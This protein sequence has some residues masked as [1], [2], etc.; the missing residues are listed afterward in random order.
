MDT[1]TS[2][3]RGHRLHLSARR[4]QGMRE[5]GLSEE[6]RCAEGW[7]HGSLTLRRKIRSGRQRGGEDMTGLPTKKDYEDYANQVRLVVGDKCLNELQ[8][9]AA[10]EYPAISTRLLCGAEVYFSDM[11]AFAEARQAGSKT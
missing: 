7:R 1:D 6:V 10:Q 9:M 5:T 8:A 2:I 4:E 3:R 11:F